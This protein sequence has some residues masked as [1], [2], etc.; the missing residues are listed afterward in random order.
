MK[1]FF[2]LAAIAAVVASMTL[3]ACGPSSPE[4][5][6][7]KQKELTQEYLEAVKAGDEAKVKE[8]QEEAE[9]LQK[10]IDEKCKDEQFKKEY[11][12]LAAKAAA[13]L[14]K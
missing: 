7:N 6:V 4:D 9:A 14:A 1:K 12:E 2:S 10:E 5:Y 13:E 3:T 8:L 11:D